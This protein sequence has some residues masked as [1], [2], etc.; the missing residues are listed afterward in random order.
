[1]VKNRFL[2]FA[3]GFIFL[4]SMS[5]AGKVMLNDGTCIEIP[6]QLIINNDLSDD[7][8]FIEEKVEEQILNDRQKE[9][10]AILGITKVVPRVTGVFLRSG[11]STEINVNKE[12]NQPSAIAKLAIIVKNKNSRHHLLYPTYAQANARKDTLQLTTVFTYNVSDI[13][14]DHKDS[15]GLTVRIRK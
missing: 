1:M 13:I 6:D 4:F 3:M 2:Y 15:N 12:P 11:I 10:M 5:Y 14:N 7:E 8:I 9:V